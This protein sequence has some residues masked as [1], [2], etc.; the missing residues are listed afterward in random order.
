M[1][2]HS[3]FLCST[4]LSQYFQSDSCTC[5]L[6]TWSQPYNGYSLPRMLGQ[7]RGLDRNHHKP[8]PFKSKRLSGREIECSNVW[9]FC[10]FLFMLRRISQSPMERPVCLRTGQENVDT[11]P[12]VVLVA[13]LAYQSCSSQHLWL[14]C[15][16]LQRTF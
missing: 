7:R 11:W 15:V 10:A 14:Q 2:L 3:T 9:S 16:F 4:S 8:E 5:A 13:I 12:F 1:I 6:H